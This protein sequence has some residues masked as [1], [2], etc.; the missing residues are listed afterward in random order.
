MLFYQK[1]NQKPNSLPTLQQE[2]GG[3]FLGATLFLQKKL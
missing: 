3:N 1:K 2:Q